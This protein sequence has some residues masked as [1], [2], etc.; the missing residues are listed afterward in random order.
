MI[1]DALTELKGKTDLILMQVTKVAVLEANHAHHNE[2]IGRAFARL[3]ALEKAHKDFTDNTLAFTNQI[4]GMAKMAYWV[5]GLMGT[6]LGA[7][8]IKIMFGGH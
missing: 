1:M 6:G 8:F 3:E 5:W 4:K 7:M 2:A